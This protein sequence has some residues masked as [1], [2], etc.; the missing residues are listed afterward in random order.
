MRRVQLFEWEDQPWL[1]RVFRDFITDHLRYTHNERMREPVNAAIGKR[2]ASL[3][4]RTGSRQIVDLCA[5][6]GGPIGRIANIASIE[7]SLPLQV[8]VTDL[9]PNVTAFQSLEKSS[10]GMITARYQSTDA[11]DVPSELRGVRTLFTAIHH[12]PPPLVKQVLADAVRKRAPVAVFEPLERSVR[13]VVLVG[14]MSFLRGFT[15]THRVGRMTVRRFLLT[16]ILPVSPAMFAWD[17]AVSALR[18]Y[19]AGELLA[20]ARSVGPRD[21]EWEAGTFEVAGP[22]GAM[23][24]TFLVG[25]P[26]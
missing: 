5:G 6:A 1:P 12:F 21:Y 13:M 24:T 10:G 23:P 2:L 14:V 11:T 19:T 22:Y 16:Y 3:L 9:Y 26:V 15:H 25:V 4:A 18:S 8:L 7:L 20:F 17:G